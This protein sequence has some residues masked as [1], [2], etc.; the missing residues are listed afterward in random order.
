[1]CWTKDQAFPTDAEKSVKVLTRE[2]DILYY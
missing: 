1:M 2:P